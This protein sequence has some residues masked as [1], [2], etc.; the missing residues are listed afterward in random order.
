MEA[1]RNLGDPLWSWA[2]ARVCK[3]KG[4][5]H[6]NA[7]AV[8]EVGPAGSTRSLGKPSTWGSGGAK[9]ELR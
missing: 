9:L 6:R 7:E 3:L 8:M 5:N 4:T 1:L 2:K